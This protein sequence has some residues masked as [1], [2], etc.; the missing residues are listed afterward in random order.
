M[1]H[2]YQKMIAL[3]VI[4][5]FLSLLP[6]YSLPFS[7]AQVQNF[8]EKEQRVS[9]QTKQNSVLPVLLGLAALTAAVFVLVLLVTKVDYDITGTW[10]FHNDFTTEGS[11][12]YDSVWSFTAYDYLDKV[13]G[14]FIRNAGGK[15]TRGKYF[16]VNE[17]KEVVFQDDA[18]TEAYVGKF[19]SK[20]T[21]SGTFQIAKVK[22]AGN[23][24]AKKR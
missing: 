19:D 6:M 3:G 15:I 18:L 21:M 11:V 13:S 20:K 5:T 24:T 1:I 16:V 22:A 4:V 14:V 23:W 8:V 2:R 17:N 10:E 12:D 9:F 7:A